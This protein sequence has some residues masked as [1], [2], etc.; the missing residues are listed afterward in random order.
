[1]P[2]KARDFV[3]GGIYHVFNRGNNRRTLFEEKV[4]FDC[5]KA[6]LHEGQKRENVKIFHYCLMNNHFHFLIKGE[7]RESVPKFMHWVQLG[8]A[9][10]FKKKHETTGHIF[11]ERY[12]SPRIAVES[13][14]LQCGRYIERN[15]VSAKMVVDAEDYPYSSAGYYVS[16]NRDSLIT[17]N[18][19]YKAMGK[20]QAKRQINYQRF[21]RIQ[22]PYAELIEDQ[23]MKY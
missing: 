5:F 15:P 19:C 4:D 23:L 14:Y 22:E 20:T 12:R 8:Y 11:E 13:Y 10:Y 16:G 21:I 7:E 18:L 9:R 17:E 2:R 1:M 3:E 6:T